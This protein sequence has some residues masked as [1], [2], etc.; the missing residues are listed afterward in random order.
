MLEAMP[1]TDLFLN[2][3]A[4]AVAADMYQLLELVP[5]KKLRTDLTKGV[6]QLLTNVGQD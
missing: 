4:D 1:W 6:D 2:R 3:T 5:D